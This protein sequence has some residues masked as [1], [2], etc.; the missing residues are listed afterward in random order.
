[1]EEE[2]GGEGCLHWETWAQCSQ[3]EAQALGR[4]KPAN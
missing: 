3:T 1:M 4:A 2:G